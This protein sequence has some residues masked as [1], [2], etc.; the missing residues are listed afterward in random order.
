MGEFVN[1]GESGM[2]AN[3][4]KE[5]IEYPTE[6]VVGIFDAIFKQLAEDYGFVSLNM[7]RNDPCFVLKDKSQ[8]TVAV[9]K[10]GWVIKSAVWVKAFSY[11]IYVGSNS[12]SGTAETI[13]EFGHSF[14]R[15]FKRYRHFLA[16]GDWFPA[17]E[18]TIF[19]VQNI[20]FK[21]ISDMPIE[22]VE[23]EPE[24]PKKTTQD[25]AGRCECGYYD[26]RFVIAVCPSCGKLL[27]DDYCW[28]GEC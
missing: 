19:L 23:V 2:A 22:S 14:N 16:T 5:P 13:A 11:V 28:Q 7:T 1:C 27:N 18:G 4:K 9:I 21:D 25:V 10:Y 3:T 17:G 8:N 12:Y 24:A 20:S 6:Q 15:E 26:P